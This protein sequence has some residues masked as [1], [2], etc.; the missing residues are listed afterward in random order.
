VTLAGLLAVGAGA[1]AGAWLRWLL[2]L[3]LN[4]LLP[5]LPLGT[6][7]ANLIG[8]YLIGVA[9]ELLGVRAGLPPEIRLFAI[10]GFLGGL[11][12][13]STFSAEA[14]G[15]LVH[16][17]WLWAAALIVV[18]VIGSI[19]LTFAGIATVRALIA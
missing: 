8:G 12:T 10:T 3:A 11:T 1:A 4:P 17:Q 14:T 5:N 7:T 19:V 15:L 2:S 6:L 9:V 13:F 16:S 18:H